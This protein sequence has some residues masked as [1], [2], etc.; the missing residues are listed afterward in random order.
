V[1]TLFVCI[2]FDGT[3]TTTDVTDAILTRFADPE[4]EEIEKLWLDGKIGSQQCLA[5][6]MKLIKAPLPEILEFIDSIPI[7][8]TFGDFVEWL[9]AEGIGHA[10]ISDGFSIFIHRILAKY[11]ISNVAIYANDLIEQR[12]TLKA[13]FPFKKAHCAAGNCKCAIAQKLCV[14]PPSVLIGDG[15]SDFC[16]AEKV[17]VV[18]AKG[19]LVTHCEQNYIGYHQFDTFME[20][21]EPL[22]EL[23]S[24]ETKLMK[25]EIAI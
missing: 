17:D 11:G 21:F 6:Q 20:I 9:K 23:C 13:Y 2:D 15:S 24:S 8:P 19:K 12:G 14:R 10:I 4:W 22:M 1:I 25:G 16:L 3:I 18:F 5:L 7:D